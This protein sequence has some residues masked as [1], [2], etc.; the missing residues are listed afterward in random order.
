MIRLSS[1]L[2]LSA[3]TLNSAMALV[4]YSDQESAS[5]TPAKSEIK[6]R[7]V[8]AARSG[9][10]SSA[11][12]YQVEFKLGY[13]SLEAQGTEGDARAN[14]Y[15]AGLHLQTAYS[16]FLDASFY[17]A[18]TR[19]GQLSDSRAEQMGNP[20][21][22]LGLNWL[23]FGSADNLASLDLT[24]GYR[25]A[26][27]HGDFAATHSDFI[28]GVETKK[29]LA[30]MALG[31][32]YQYTLVGDN[33]NTDELQLGNIH[34]L[35][36]ELGYQATSDIIFALAAGHYSFSAAKED[37][38]NG[39][40][41]K[42]TSSYF[43][44]KLNLILSPTFGLEMGA[45]FSGKRAEGIEQLLQQKLFAYKGIYGTSLFINSIVTF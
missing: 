25:L 3:F 18:S 10:S 12:A 28:F 39:L 4:D 26:Q 17:M 43:S 38:T 27:D 20:E 45:I 14:L 31:L 22:T 8:E 5:S 6:R 2:L 7:P 40:S 30:R 11:S 9:S 24:L 16:L 41:E 33:K 29:R 36:A 44:P 21:F 15:R 32:G 1:I 19:S 13:E 37:Q 42:M 34:H 23:Q 35:F